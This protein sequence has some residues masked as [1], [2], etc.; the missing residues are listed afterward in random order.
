MYIESLARV[1]SHYIRGIFLCYR[2]QAKG[3]A[4]TARAART[5]PLPWR[6][7]W[8]RFQNE[9]SE[10]SGAAT[11]CRSRYTGADEKGAMEDTCERAL[12]ALL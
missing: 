6:A 1:M 3:G 2:W 12:E 8:R 7:E 4:E 10:L 9:I 5:G 11:L